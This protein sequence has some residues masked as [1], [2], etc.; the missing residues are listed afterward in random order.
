MTDEP[1]SLDLKLLR[2]FL[3]IEE[4]RTFQGAADRMGMSG[5]GVT[6][7]MQRLERALGAR[8]FDRKS[9]NLRKLTPL[10]AA[11][12]PLAVKIIALNDEILLS[13]RETETDPP[14]TAQ[15]GP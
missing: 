5:A 11:L 10:G 15:T 1:R 13:L 4:V 9:N 7:Q 12:L 8:L 3:L 2:I 6:L 14:D